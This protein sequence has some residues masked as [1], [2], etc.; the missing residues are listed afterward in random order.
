MAL[1][2]AQIRSAWRGMLEHNGGLGQFSKPDLAS[3][4]Q[5]ADAWADA[6]ATSYNSALPQPFRSQA[7]TA[8]KAVLLAY[9]AMK[10][11]GVL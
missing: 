1:T 4:A 5:A 2:A 7:T 9:V 8:Q 10:R 11:T 3:A 6:N